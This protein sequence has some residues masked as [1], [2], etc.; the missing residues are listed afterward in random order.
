M[1]YARMGSWKMDFE[2]QEFMFSRELKALLVMEE[3][4][5]K[6][7]VGRFPSRFRRSGRPHRVLE[8]FSKSPA[9]KDNKDYETSFSFRVITGMDGCDTFS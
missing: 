4:R 1:T 9:A 6:I 8:E 3:E 5:K 2:S 7:A